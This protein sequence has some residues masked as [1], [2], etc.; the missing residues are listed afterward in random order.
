MAIYLQSVDKQRIKQKK[1]LSIV[2]HAKA[3][4]INFIS[5]R[6]SKVA[7]T[8]YWMKGKRDKQSINT[9]CSTWK[10]F[11]RVFSVPFLFIVVIDSVDDTMA[12]V[13][14]TICSLNL[15]I[16]N[17]L[18]RSRYEVLNDTAQ[19]APTH[20]R[21]NILVADFSIYRINKFSLMFTQWH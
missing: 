12:H 6:I 21:T 20:E 17:S 8:L 13:S 7:N 3:D 19:T 10:T 16:F 9:F 1:D 15:R 5:E 4:V 11:C 2:C 14:P 18:T